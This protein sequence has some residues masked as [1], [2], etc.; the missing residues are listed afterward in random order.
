MILNYTLAADCLSVKNI[1]NENLCGSYFYELQLFVIC[2]QVK[3]KTNKYFSIALSPGLNPTFLI[4][5]VRSRC[6]FLKFHRLLFVCVARKEISERNK[7]ASEAKR[8]QS[9]CENEKSARIFC[10]AARFQFDIKRAVA[11]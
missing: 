2:K 10:E 6:V 4:H 11:F 9:R 7:S 1:S 5:W 3:H 8:L